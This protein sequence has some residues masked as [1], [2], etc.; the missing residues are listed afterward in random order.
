MGCFGLIPSTKK[1]PILSHPHPHPGSK[2]GTVFSFLSPPSVSLFFFIICKENSCLAEGAQLRRSL[3]AQR[4]QQGAAG[5]LNPFPGKMWAA[6][7]ILKLLRR[8]RGAS[9]GVSQ[10]NRGHLVRR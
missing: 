9:S 7:Q 8:R 3:A 2:L 1:R 6:G 5:P 10:C 4:A